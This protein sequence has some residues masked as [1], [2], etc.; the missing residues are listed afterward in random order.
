MQ[1]RILED[2]PTGF[3]RDYELGETVRCQTHMSTGDTS[4]L[5]NHDFAF[6]KRSD[7]SYSYAILAERS[8]E[9]MLFAMNASGATKKISKKHWSSLLCL[10]SR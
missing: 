6:V 9:F 5:E 8:E 10:V 3:R 4:S 2:Q 7:G 1:S